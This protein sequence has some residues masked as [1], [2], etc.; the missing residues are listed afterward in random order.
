M[1]LTGFMEC[2]DER[3]L[4]MVMNKLKCVRN[5]EVINNG[6]TVIVDYT[7]LE[8]ETAFEEEETIA[9]ITDLVESVEVHGFGITK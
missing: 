2:Q 3:E 6:L 5:I 4:D 9:R 1:L 8:T 7:P